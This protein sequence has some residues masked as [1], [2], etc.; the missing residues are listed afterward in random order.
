VTGTGYDP[1][2]DIL[3]LDGTPVEASGS[4]ALTSLLATIALANTAGLEKKEGSWRVVGDPTEGALLTLAAKGG[5]P[6]ES[7]APSHQVLKEI[8]FDSDR[9]RMNL[10]TLDAAGAH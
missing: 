2:G 1:A 9:H 7:I 10:I 8:P 6:K 4:E 5:L 3:A